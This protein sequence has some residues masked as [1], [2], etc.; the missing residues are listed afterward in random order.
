MFSTLHNLY[1]TSVCVEYT[2]TQ[3]VSVIRVITLLLF[4]FFIKNRLY[5][6]T[7]TFE[8]T[9]DYQTSHYYLPSSPNYRHPSQRIPKYRRSIAKDSYNWTYFSSAW[10][11]QLLL[12]EP[13]PPQITIIFLFAF[14][15]LRME[16]SFI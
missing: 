9:F 1:S 5:F 16:E 8:C 7:G 14:V 12:S 10:S 13:H 15:F 6:D 4:Y 11:T 3:K 2:G